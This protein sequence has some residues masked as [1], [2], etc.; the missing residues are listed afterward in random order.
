MNCLKYVA[1]SEAHMY[2]FKNL[3]EKLFLCNVYELL[4]YTKFTSLNK[5]ILTLTFLNTHRNNIGYC[6]C[7][8]PI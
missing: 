8:T 4:K 7:H 3:K 5:S 2:E 1:A 6:V